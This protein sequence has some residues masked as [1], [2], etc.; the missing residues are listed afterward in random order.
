M[1]NIFAT[2]QKKPIPPTSPHT[3]HRTNGPSTSKEAAYHVKA[4]ELEAMVLAFI[5]SQG[6]R[7]ATNYECVKYFKPDSRF[8]IT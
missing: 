2:K 8:D 4:T 7:G 1:A 5:K 3:L 6:D